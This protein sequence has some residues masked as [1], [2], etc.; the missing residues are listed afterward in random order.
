MCSMAALLM[1]CITSD[2]YRFNSF[3]LECFVEKDST[4]L[5]PFTSCKDLL[6]LYANIGEA[7]L[8]QAKLLP[9]VVNSATV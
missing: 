8:C 5:F 6:L 7:K 3:L 9:N 1:Q 4:F 2:L